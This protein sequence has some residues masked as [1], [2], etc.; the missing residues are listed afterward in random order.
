MSYKKLFWG[1]LLVFIGVLFILKNLGWIFFDWWTIFRLWPLILI[2]WGISIIPVKNY[3]KL[4][5]SL[6]SVVLAILLVNKYDH[7]E[8][9]FKNWNNQN[10][11]WRFDMDDD[12]DMDDTTG[13]SNEQEMFQSY[14]TSI[15]QA[16]LKFDAAIGDFRISDSILDDK[17]IVFRKKGN[18]GTYSMTSNQEDNRREVILKI[19][20]SKMK[21]RNT[22]NSVRLMLNT[23]PVWDFD[24]DVGAANIDFDLSRYKVGKVKVDGGASSIHLKLG[25]INALTDVDIDAGAASIDIDVPETAGVE[26]RTETVL[27]SRNINGFDRLS[28]GHFKTDNF[29][30]ATSKILIKVDAGV[31]SLT[32]NRY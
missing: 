9:P 29:E 18:I 23:A 27:S 8:K 25:D 24:L 19:N 31:S 12:E 4:T 14:D 10:H 7:R 32:I 13:Y 6:L 11:S 5:L 15:T 20:E 26:L 22:G 3:I 28:K 21:Y 30:S 17:L 2:L 1:I 16:F